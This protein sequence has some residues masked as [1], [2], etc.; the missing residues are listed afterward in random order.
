M[1]VSKRTRFEVLRRDSFTCRYCRSAENPLTVDHVVPVALGGSDDPSNLV[2]ACKDCNAGKSS[3][4]PDDSLVA[5]VHADA[6]R[7]AEMIRQAYDVMVERLKDKLEYQ[8]E[9]IDA[10]PWDEIISTWKGSIATF[11]RMGV[12]IEI[13]LDA[14]EITQSKASVTTPD[15]R[16][17]YMCGIVWKQAGIVT[18][19]VLVREALAGAWKSESDLD[20]IRYTAFMDGRDRVLREGDPYLKMLRYVCDKATPKTPGLVSHCFNRPQAA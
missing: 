15:G 13:L 3:A 6:L 7:H 12:P 20:D 14:L 5:D 8:D 4:S 11:W 1:A 16:F 18:D 9:F 17:R 10:W 2:A 19:E